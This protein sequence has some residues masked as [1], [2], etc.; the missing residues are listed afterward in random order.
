MVSGS[1]QCGAGSGPG[2]W[3]KIEPLAANGGGGR[4]GIGEAAGKRGRI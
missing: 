3:L 1:G 2:E 4:K